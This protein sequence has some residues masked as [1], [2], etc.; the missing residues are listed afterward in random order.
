[1]TKANRKTKAQVTENETE[2]EA[3]APRG[4]SVVDPRYKK[5][6]GKSQRCGDT[7]SQRMADSEHTLAQ[8][9]DDNGIDLTRWS[10]L[11]GG[12]QR[13]NL[14]NVLRGIEA[15]GEQPLVL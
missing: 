7:I 15:K 14:G 9:A 6:Y 8:I 1:M 12:M 10:H 13:M 11:N 3:K 2:T 5:V 4:K